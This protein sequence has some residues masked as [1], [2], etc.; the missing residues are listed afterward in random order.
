MIKEIEST[1]GHYKKLVNILGEKHLKSN[2]ESPFDFIR[3]A[4]DGVD[5]AVIRNFRVHFN[6]S[7][8]L[9]A[10]MLNV[11][12]PTIYRWTKSNKKLERNLSVKLF[13]IADLF[14]YG[15]EVFGDDKNFFKW[16]NLPNTALGGMEPFELVEIP[17]GMAKIRDVLG[18]IEHGIYS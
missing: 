11:S 4:T 1:T 5:A 2:V 6:L 8:D 13:E 18:R 15:S 9:M 3:I 17:G 12:S 7:R 14:L 10:T 16:L